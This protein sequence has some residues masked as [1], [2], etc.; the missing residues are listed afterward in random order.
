[1][2]ELLQNPSS[3]VDTPVALEP[4]LSREAARD[5]RAVLHLP[6]PY[7]AMF[8]PLGFCRGVRHQ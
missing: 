2:I 3:D 6:L 1:M 4:D 7:R 8:Y 5:E